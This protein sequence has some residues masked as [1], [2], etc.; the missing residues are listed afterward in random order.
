MYVCSITGLSLGLRFPISTFS[1]SPSSLLREDTIS[2]V[3]KERR[4]GKK[5]EKK[6]TERR[7]RRFQMDIFFC[8]EK[9]TTEAYFAS[10]RLEMKRNYRK[11]VLPVFSC[12][13]FMEVGGGKR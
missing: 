7:R 9:K 3:S 11:I 5:K 8:G 12:R 1:V 4:E 10:R 13:C 2:L 6:G